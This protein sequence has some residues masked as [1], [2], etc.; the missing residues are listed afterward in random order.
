MMERKKQAIRKG[1]PGVLQPTTLV[2]FKQELKHF[3]LLDLFT[4]IILAQMTA[5]YEFSF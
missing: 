5:P 3:Q 4:S 1:E 2:H